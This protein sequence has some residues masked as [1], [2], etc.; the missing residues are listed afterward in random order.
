M[1]DNPAYGISSEIN[2]TV[3]NKYE[4]IA[5][6]ITSID[7]NR[8]NIVRFR[9]VPKCSTVAFVLS[10]LALIVTAV[11]LVLMFVACFFL[12][13]KLPQNTKTT[14]EG[15]YSSLYSIGSNA[16]IT[17]LENSTCS[18]VCA[19]NGTTTN[20]EL[21]GYL[22]I[23]CREENARCTVECSGYRACRYA[24]IICGRDRNCLSCSGKGSCYGAIMTYP[25]VSMPVL[26]CTGSDSCWFANITCPPQNNCTINCN[27]HSSCNYARVTCPTGDYSCNILCT[28][29]LSCSKLSITN[30][31]NVYL[32][33]C[34]SAT[35]CA[36]ISGPMTASTECLQ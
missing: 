20:Y 21:C 30:T 17:C 10:I 11:C 33:C 9:A 28:D 3:E 32:Q 4:T 18:I 13:F 19:G 14:Q 2:G 22:R 1:E 31:H 24:N 36:G 7:K 26:Q 8:I 16:E 34:G 12:V 29:P 5:T 25:D 15:N 6:T 23:N 27:G 35:R